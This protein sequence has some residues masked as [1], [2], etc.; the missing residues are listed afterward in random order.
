M[1]IFLYPRGT[2]EPIR[3]I[4]YNKFI[5]NNIYKM[6]YA[7]FIGCLIIASVWGVIYF[8]RKDLRKEIVFGSFLGAPFGISEF[9]YVPEYW[10]PPQY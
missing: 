5:K 2:F 10:T 7:Y 6:Q 8:Y 9:L 1:A 4:W 3:G